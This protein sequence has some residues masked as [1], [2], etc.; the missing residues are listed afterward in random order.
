MEFHRQLHVLA[1]GGAVVASGGD[2]HTLEEQAEGP[3]DDD[4]PVEPVK[5]D[6][7]G[8][9]GAVILQHLHTGQELAGH[10]VADHPAV[11]DLRAVAGPHGAAHR[12]HAGVLQHRADDLLQRVVLE[13]GVRVQAEEVGVAGHID[14][15][16]QGVR[17]AA[18]F[19][20]HQ[21][22]GHLV[23]PGLVDLL[24][25]LAGDAPLDGPLDLPHV[26]GV[27]QHLGGVVGGAVI[28]H[29]DLIELVVQGQQG[30]DG[31][32]DGHLLVVGGHQDGNRHIVVVGQLILQPVAPLGG[33]KV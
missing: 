2:D 3:R 30:T 6:P 16:I 28:H 22:D 27:P 14:P 26:K 25:R 20:P 21:G 4:I 9:E 8:Q 10:P 17:L 23:G 1:H 24:L 31:G 32:L 19:L 13:H 7:G 11:L 12:N 18:V 5:E 15:H 29:H 33:V